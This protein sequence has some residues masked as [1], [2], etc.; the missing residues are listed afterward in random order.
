MKHHKKLNLDT[1]LWGII[2]M[3]PF[4]GYLIAF[5]RQG[6]VPA[7]F[8]YIDEHFAFTYVQSII[9]SIWQKAFNCEL[10]LSGYLSYLVSVE[11][12]HVLFDVIV[13]VPRFA[14]AITD[15][16]INFAGGKE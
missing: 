16:A 2:W 11:I 13:F 10:V 1:L 12:A 5:W 15:K 9:T 14:H 4:F 6:T 7:L 3:L 8:T